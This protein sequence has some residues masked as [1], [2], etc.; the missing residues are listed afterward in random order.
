M[1]EPSEDVSETINKCSLTFEQLV[2]LK[3]HNQQRMDLIRANWR[4]EGSKIPNEEREQ[5]AE[6]FRVLAEKIASLFGKNHAIKIERK[7]D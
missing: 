2:E 7:P 4:V 3:A 5:A 6:R 1:I